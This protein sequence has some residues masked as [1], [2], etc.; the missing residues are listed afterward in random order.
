M[1]AAARV[2]LPAR[3][4]SPTAASARARGW[5]FDPPGWLA[6]VVLALVGGGLALWTWGKN[7]HLFV[8]Y[9]REVYVP[10]RLS[11]GDVLYRDIAWFN[12]PLSAYFNALV[13]AVFGTDIRT[14]ALVNL[15]VV[16]AVTV[17]VWHCARA[18]ANRGTALC[19]G[20][21]WLVASA[22]QHL[23]AS[24]NFN[25]VA[26]YS[27]EMTHGVALG[28]L[29][30][31]LLRRALARGTWWAF[32]MC[33]AALGLCLLTKAEVA[34]ATLVATA[35]GVALGRRG[36]LMRSGGAVLVGSAIPVLS[37]FAALATAMPAAEAARGTLGS[38]VYLTNSGLRDLPYYQWCTGLG[39]P[40]LSLQ[41]TGVWALA[42]AGTLVPGLALALALGTGRTK[43][44]GWTLLVGALAA[45]TLLSDALAPT[46]VPLT[47]LDRWLAVGTFGGLLAASVLIRR[48]PAVLPIAAAS[49]IMLS[50]PWR[51]LVYEQTFRPLGVCVLAVLVAKCWR[52]RTDR[53]A[54]WAVAFAAFALVLLSKICLH[55]RISHY[56]FGLAM[57]AL[58]VCTVALLRLP[59]LVA[60]WGGR[61]GVARATVL[62]FLATLGLGLLSHYDR[63]LRTKPATFGGGG[64]QFL[65]Q[66]AAIVHEWARAA[67]WIATRTA[68]G[69]TVTVMPEGVMLNYL[70]R[71]KNPTRH[72]NFMPPEVAM[73]GEERILHDVQRNPPDFVV[74]MHRP[75]IEYGLPLFGKDY[76]GTIYRW[77]REHYTVVE[78]IGDEP[79]QRVDRHGAL[80]LERN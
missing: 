26:P 62:G 66:D 46:G 15:A 27:H 19:C 13:F 11:E 29:T 35:V 28:L 36:L 57:P 68:A 78:R 16:A 58:L 32:S 4:K 5:V 1:K 2:A 37:A 25:W 65:V 49:L 38:F 61:G 9:G 47:L 22:F 17:L 14:Q 21:V 77:V 54:A 48:L 10:W 45:F 60:T 18:L 63:Q 40:L 73:F 42:L 41:G 53:S 3:P 67:Q 34:L 33:G 64:D 30:I 24:G 75:S 52:Y 70:T 80:I 51:T 31:W 55:V 56:G 69:A 12:G 6:A 43:R 20:L 50:M 8:D 7:F 74:L 39:A 79:L 72:V 59:A 44:I 71:R 23:D 76:A